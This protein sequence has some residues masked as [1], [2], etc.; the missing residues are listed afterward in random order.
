[1]ISDGT[2]GP[3]ALADGVDAAMRLGKNAEAVVGQL[4]GRFYEQTYRGNVYAAG[5]VLTSISNATFTTATTGATATPIIGLYNPLGSGV[6]AVLLQAHMNVIMTALQATGCGGFTWMATSAAGPISTG[7]AP[8]KLSTLTATGSQCKVLAGTALTGMTGTLALLR[9]SSM[10]GGSSYNTA[11]LATAAGFQTQAVPG[12]EHID[13][14]IIVPPNAVVGL[15]A[16]TTPVAHSATSG[17]V[18]EE[19]PTQ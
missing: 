5:M 14:S 7:I 12:I 11:L 9:G 13:G 6:N 4:H 17:L 15:F 8:F 3:R 1:M 18:F 10:A 16:N 2:V 19:V